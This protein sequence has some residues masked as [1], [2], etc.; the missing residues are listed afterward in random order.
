VVVDIAKQRLHGGTGDGAPHTKRLRVGLFGCPLDTGNKGVSA[1]GLSTIASLAGLVPQLDVTLFDF[2]K[3]VRYTG[4][5]T[6]GNGATVRQVGCFHSRRYYRANNLV[7]MRLAA[8]LGLRWLHPMVRQLAGL[9]VIMDVS[10]GDS[11]S[12]IYGTYRFTGVTLP[13]LLAL[14]LGIPLILLPQTYGPYHSPRLRATAAHVLRRAQQVWARDA[15]SL[16]MVRELVGEAFDPQRHRCGVDMAFGL[17]K[18]APA[19]P[20]L[21][22]R[23]ARHRAGGRLLVGLNISGL[24]YNERDEGSYGGPDADRTRFG[25]RDP[26]AQIVDLLLAR[27]TRLSGVQVLLVPHVTGHADPHC[28]D[29]AANRAALAKLEPAARD[30]VMLIPGHLSAGEMKWVIGQCD[31]F[32]GTRMHACIAA[33]SQGVPCTSIAYSDKTEGVFETAGVDDGVVDPRTSHAE[34][35]VHDVLA[36]LERR[37]TTAKFLRARLPALQ[38][39][40]ELQCRSFVEAAMRGAETCA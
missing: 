40:L 36:G 15:N 35:L 39:K 21:L 14:D 11:F 17:A 2:G 5:A 37:Q 3:G 1:L 23:I 28:G 8:R 24:L 30:R 27:L 4:E 26:Y 6:P 34:E 25:F 20:D 13:K 32:C 18:S 7:Q 9:D 12:D 19:E 38:S 16:R 10:G 22:A 29:V 31:W 33:L